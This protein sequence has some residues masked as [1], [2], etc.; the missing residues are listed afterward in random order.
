MGLGNRPRL[1]GLLMLPARTTPGTSPRVRAAY[2][3]IE[4]NPQTGRIDAVH[5]VRSPDDLPSDIEGGPDAFILPGLVDAHLH[6]PQFDSIGVEGVTLLDWLSGAIFP[7]EARWADPRYAAAM[8][9]RVARTLLSHGTTAVA[10]FG[11]VHAEGTRRAAA[12]LARAGLCGY[13]GQT[14]MDRPSPG[15]AP[16]D[17]VRS[18]DD[19]LREAREAMALGPDWAGAPEEACGWSEG[20]VGGGVGRILPSLN[21]R[22]ALSCTPELMAGVAWIARN[23]ASRGGGYPRIIHTHWAETVEECRQVGRLYGVTPDAAGYLEV[24][25]RSGLIGGRKAGGAG[26]RTLLA[27]GVQ[28]TPA[29]GARLARDP[30]AVVVHCPTANL[31]LHSGVMHRANLRGARMAL[32]SDVAGGPEVSM[33][34][35]AKAM[36]DTA[37]AAALGAAGTRGRSAGAG[38]GVPSA[39]EAWWQITGGNAAAVGM[40]GVGVI[41]RGA[42]ADVLVVRPRGPLPPFERALSWLLHAWDERWLERTY[43]AGRVAWSATGRVG[44]RS[45]R[46]AGARRTATGADT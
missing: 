30:G 25:R 27:H 18:T 21:P 22:F 9:E 1:G 16:N 26:V 41:E 12:A 35:V 24:Y 34:R 10:A 4:I 32:G 19:L 37:H 38:A 20:W 31:F 11:T 44:V 28:A 3:W 2:G 6:L 40:R 42:W 17:L 33:V 13:V 39:E 43:T 45:G 14:L 5:R 8:G 29:E 46:S 36:I 15:T 23:V 7:A